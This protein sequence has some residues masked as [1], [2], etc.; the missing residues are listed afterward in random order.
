MI[1]NKKGAVIQASVKPDWVPVHG[2]N[3][4]QKQEIALWHPPQ[5]Y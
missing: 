2:M 4:R 1:L 5:S 3:I